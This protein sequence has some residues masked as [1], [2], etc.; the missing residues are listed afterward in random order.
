[1]IKRWAD[2]HFFFVEQ[3]VMMAMFSPSGMPFLFDVTGG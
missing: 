3:F 2:A 1:M